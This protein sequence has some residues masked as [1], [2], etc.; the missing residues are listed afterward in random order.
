MTIK[1][2]KKYNSNE[3]LR[4]ERFILRLQPLPFATRLKQ[5]CKKMTKASSSIAKRL[6][7]VEKQLFT[8]KTHLSVAKMAMMKCKA[9]I[10]HIQ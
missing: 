4:N 7:K 1:Q 3:H 6:A 9:A 5:K 2:K 10:E 8:F